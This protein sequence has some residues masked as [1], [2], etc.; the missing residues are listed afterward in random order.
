VCDSLREASPTMGDYDGELIF[1]PGEVERWP[2][3]EALAWH[4][5]EWADGVGDRPLYPEERVRSIV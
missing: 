4:R 1:L 2:R 3:R 5:G